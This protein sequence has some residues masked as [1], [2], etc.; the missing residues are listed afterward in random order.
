[1]HILF[2][3]LEF[4][5]VPG[6]I[7]VFTHNLC[8]QLCNLGHRVD[9]LKPAHKGYV[10][11]K[12]EHPYIVHKYRELKFFSS[13]VPLFNILYLNI[14]KK[15]DII[16]VGQLMGTH[17]IG[18]VALKKFRSVPY[19]IL[20]H[21]NDLYYSMGNKIDRPVAYNLLHN[22]SL[23][24]SNSHETAKRIRQKGYQGPLQI[25]HP[26]VDIDE[27]RPDIDTSE[28]LQKYNP[29]KKKVILSISRL[30]QRKGHENVLKALCTVIKKVPDVL[31]LIAGDG[32]ERDYLRK[33]VYE[34][35]LQ[36]FVLF[37]GHVRQE[38]LPALY[39]SC[40]V[41]VLPALVKNKGQDYEGFGIVYSEA[42]ACSKP[43]I[44]GRSGGV[45][46]AVIDGVTGILVDPENVDQIAQNLIRLLTDKEY[47][48]WLGENGRKRVE[49]KL[50]WRIIGKQVERALQKIIF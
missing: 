4:P 11:V 47:A 36:R 24:F 9:I 23:V 25:L 2:V 42:S 22:A 10:E 18:V 14:Q 26:G 29:E 5:P 41:F 16:F 7:A 21:G 49:E 15:Y 31:Y 46:D 8:V 44:A 39:C 30:S 19:V 38:L 1:M 12:N 48:R 43:I 3:T 33:L 17:A 37:I 45:K 13:I 35:G 27:F 50:T 40:D 34:L 6:G 32:E 28:I 20:S